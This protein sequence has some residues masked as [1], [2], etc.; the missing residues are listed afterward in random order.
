MRKLEQIT[1][2]FRLITPVLLGVII[3]LIV[4]G[5]ASLKADIVRIETKLDQHQSWANIKIEDYQQFKIDTE[6]RM[7]TIES[8]VK[9]IPKEEAKHAL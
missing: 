7:S 2:I 8:R 4:D 3:T 9:Y 5:K 1:P 6:H